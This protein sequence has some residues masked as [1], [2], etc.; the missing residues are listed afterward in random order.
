MNVF[1][2]TLN[3][4][5]NNQNYQNELALSSTE[6]QAKLFEELNQTLTATILDSVQ[7]YLEKLNTN[8]SHQAQVL[9]QIADDNKK[10]FANDKTDIQQEVKVYADFPNATSAN[11]IQKALENLV[12]AA[13]QHAYTT[14]R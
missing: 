3:T 11:E 2:D 9:T 8:I 1:K 13:T 14:R 7:S 12:N 10:S 6:Y 5:L 4:Q